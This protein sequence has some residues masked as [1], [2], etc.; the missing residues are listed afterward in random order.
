MPKRKTL[1]ALMTLSFLSLG[2][3]AAGSS[4][5]LQSKAGM[6]TPKSKDQAMTK[7]KDVA[8]KES[9]FACNVAGISGEQRP[10]YLALAKK[11][12][13]TRQEVRELA[14]G[15]AFRFSVEAATIQDLAEFITYERLCCPFFDLE[16]VVER[17]GGPAWLRLRGREGVKEFIR[18]EFGIQ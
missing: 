7:T 17:E 8:T 5:A 2:F 13:S 4:A 14:D 3:F 16:L 1:R 12:V 6:T 18:T 15:Y 11:L 9:P 10:R